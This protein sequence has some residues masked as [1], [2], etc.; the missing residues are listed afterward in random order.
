MWEYCGWGWGGWGWGGAAGGVGGSMG[1]GT[2]EE[3]E[4]IIIL[5]K[6]ILRIMIRAISDSRVRNLMHFDT[7][8]KN[9]LFSH[10]E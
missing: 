2:G 8:D 10:A 7:C 4:G 5:A 3:G 9:A 1:G 6:G